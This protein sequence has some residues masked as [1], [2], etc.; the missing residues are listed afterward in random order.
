M[1]GKDFLFNTEEDEAE[2]EF[3]EEDS[4]VIR[5]YERLA[6]EREQLLSEKDESNGEKK[7]S[8]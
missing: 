1:I 4:D 8:N 3:L 2:F 5:F 6:K 7:E